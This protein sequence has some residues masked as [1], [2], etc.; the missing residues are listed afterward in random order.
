MP[1][2]TFRSAWRVCATVV[3]LALCGCAVASQSTRVPY[4]PIDE[5]SA[6]P[7]LFATR[8]AVLD[9][10]LHSDRDALSRWLGAQL[11][12]SDVGRDIL[13]DMLAKGAESASALTEVLTHG[14]AFMGAGRSKFCAPYWAA[15]PPSVLSLPEHLVFEGLPGAVIVT[16]SVVR[17]RPDAS[18]PEIGRL[19]LE[20]VQVF[21][22]EQADPEGRFVQITFGRT[23][24]FV[25]RSDV[26]EIEGAKTACFDLVDGAWRL[27]TFTF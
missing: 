5:A 12:G 22:T 19:S 20:L 27:T 17:A 15:R 2:S 13:I 8:A 16:Q 14:G 25:E 1:S 26:R 11:N 24:A 10:L 7:A 6:E 9:A 23:R 4:E 3:G 21:F 18:A